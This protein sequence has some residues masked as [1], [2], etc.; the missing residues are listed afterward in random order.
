[1]IAGSNTSVLVDEV[2]PKLVRNILDQFL[3]F[4]QFPG[5]DR[6]GVINNFISQSYKET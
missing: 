5:K 3:Q 6:A 4:T 1:M 2:S